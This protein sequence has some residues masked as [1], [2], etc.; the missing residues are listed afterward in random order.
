MIE[1]QVYN[2]IKSSA[3]NKVYPSVAKAGTKAPFIVYQRI[4]TSPVTSLD[5]DNS[6]NSVRIQISCMGV[7]YKEAKD[8]AESV[9]TALAASTLKFR[10]DN[11]LDDYDIESKIHVIITD[12][13]FWQK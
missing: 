7:D 13:I 10:L 11:Q 6:L 2:L 8:L 12:F 5:G 1:S 3:S 9:K 4:S